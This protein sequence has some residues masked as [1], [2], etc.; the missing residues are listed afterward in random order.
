VNDVPGLQKFLDAVAI[1]ATDRRALPLHARDFLQRLANGVFD[2][3]TFIAGNLQSLIARPTEVT[4][5]R[6]VASL[7]LA[8]AICLIA[9]SA[10]G[11]GVFRLWKHHEMV[12]RAENP[13]QQQMPDAIR[14][15]AQASGIDLDSMEFIGSA[16]VRDQPFADSIGKWIVYRF[17]DFIRDASFDT[18]AHTL[19]GDERKLARTIVKKYPKVSEEEYTGL[20]PIVTAAVDQLNQDTRV[21]LLLMGPVVFASLLVFLAIINVVSVPAFGTSLGLRL[22]ELSVVDH[23]GNAASRLRHFLRNL[24]AHSALIGGI[25]FVVFAQIFSG[26]V[27]VIV[28]IT[29]IA[30]VGCILSGLFFISV[31]IWPDRSL[32]DRIAGTHVVLR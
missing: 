27:L 16:I 12:F 21:I 20:N 28:A 9:S 2:R 23:T 15:Y 4:R 14:L 31:L 25:I 13:A 5:R 11:I 22:F 29:G 17:G 26:S 7:I 1:Y 30:I 6:R 18:A 3:A 10:L 24:L 32:Y 19:T 8:P